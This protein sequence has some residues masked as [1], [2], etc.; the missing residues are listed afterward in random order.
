MFHLN[1]GVQ[2]LEGGGQ[3]ILGELFQ[4]GGLVGVFFR[5]GEN[6][7][8]QLFQPVDL[9][10]QERV[11]DRLA[12]QTELGQHGVVLAGLGGGFFLRGLGGNGGGPPH[13]QKIR[14]VVDVGPRAEVPVVDGVFQQLPALLIGQPG[15]GEEF[16]QGDIVP[17]AHDFIQPLFQLAGLFHPHPENQGA[18]ASHQLGQAGEELFQGTEGGH[19]VESFPQRDQPHK[20]QESSQ[21]GTKVDEALLPLLGGALL[22]GGGVRAGG[23]V[24]GSVGR[25]GR[26]GGLVGAVLDLGVPAGGLLAGGA[27]VDGPQDKQEDRRLGR[28]TQQH[29]QDDGGDLGEI[30][31]PFWFHDI[32]S[33]RAAGRK[34][35]RIPLY[36]SGIRRVC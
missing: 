36:Y 12:Q 10:P 23:I 16:S 25:P 19:L 9:G 33:S 13:H 14:P 20:E 11:S 22:G 34:K 24:V 29:Q 17:V 26:I 27:A 7:L 8:G 18:A 30:V 31:F 1:V 2:Q 35:S 4:L 15:G 32:T 5:Q 21:Q 6:L 28:Q 3:I